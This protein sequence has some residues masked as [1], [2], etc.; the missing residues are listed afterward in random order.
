MIQIVS[1]VLT[2]KHRVL[3]SV[4]QMKGEMG[5][6]IRIGVELGRGLPGEVA[7]SQPSGP[8]SPMSVLSGRG[9]LCGV[10]LWTP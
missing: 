3:P 5:K 4:T 9:H 2:L 7:G 8:V 1:I 10:T 6:A